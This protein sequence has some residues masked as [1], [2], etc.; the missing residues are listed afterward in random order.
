MRFGEGLSITL[1][2]SLLVLSAL[3][4]IPAAGQ[5]TLPG[6]PTTGVIDSTFDG[7][8]TQ[9]GPGWTGADGTFSLPL[10]DGTNL[11][12]WSDSYIGTV[13]P[14]TR[15]RKSYLITAH[16]SLTILN[17]ATGSWTTVGYPPSTTSYFAP[18]SKSD[19]YWVGS[20]YVTEPSAG[21][22]EINILLLE[23][24]G[25]FK[26]V[27]HAVATLSWP[28]LSIISITP[29]AGLNTTLEWGTKIVQSGDY[30]YIYGLK[31][32]GTDTKTPYVA[33]TTSLSNMTNAAKWEFWNATKKKW[34]A[35][36]SNATAMSGVEAVTPEYSVD[37]MSYNGGTFYL[38]VGMN[39]LSPAYPLWDTV[40]TWYSCSPQGPWSDETTVYTTP[41]AGAN[42]CK[43][44]T[45]VTYNAKAH[46]EFTDADGILISYNVNANTSTDLVC[47]ND[48]MPRFVRVQIPGVTDAK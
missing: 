8:V 39:P 14:S 3:I 37:A 32:P 42:G 10:P 38:M 11:W 33:R 19:W 22:Y 45:L 9:N 6:A 13:N 5:C 46:S 31:D 47:A 7:Y 27:G 18:M 36:E 23:W 20:G 29:I 34:L 41:E 35:G 1:F 43:V 40:T 28:S 2:V 15:R 48:Y 16:N 12:M 26:L 30:Y 44:G 24:T 21:N 17:Q 4:S 25:A